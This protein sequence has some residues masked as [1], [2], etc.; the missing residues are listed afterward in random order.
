[1]A[2]NQVGNLFISYTDRFKYKYY[3]TANL[4]FSKNIN[5]ACPFYLLKSDDT[6]IQNGNNITI[7]TSNKILV[8]DKENNLQLVDRNLS[9]HYK[10]DFMIMDGED[11]N[12][13]I[14]FGIKI[15]FIVDQLNKLALRF[16]YSLSLGSENDDTPTLK[17]GSYAEGREIGIEIFQFTLE[18]INTLDDNTRQYLPN[19][20]STD[21][22]N[23][24]KK[25]PLAENYKG[26]ILI[27]ILIIILIM[28][29]MIIK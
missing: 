11:D 21:L 22:S 10:N 14:S 2:L 18:K 25:D 4:Q 15:Y 1:M 6:P 20:N 24:V 19:Q 12:K 13:E 9:Y 3:L 8:L 23:P 27:A 29:L 17:C 16:Y 5:D 7:N 26:I 28:C